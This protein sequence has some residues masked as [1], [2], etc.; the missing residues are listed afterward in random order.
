VQAIGLAFVGRALLQSPAGGAVEQPAA[1][2]QTLSSPEPGVPGGRIRAVFARSMSVDALHGLLRS[3]HLT[4]VGGP[5]EA[6]VFTLGLEAGAASPEAA[7][8]GLRADPMVQFAE[9]TPAT[10]VARP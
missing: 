6:G 5:T 10:G 9:P 4:I 2:Y 7:L 8:Q 1:G 3:Q